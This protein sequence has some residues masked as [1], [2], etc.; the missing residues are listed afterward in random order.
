MNVL[1]QTFEAERRRL[2]GVAYR[3]LGSATEA[4][5]VL[6][7]AWLRASRYGAKV[8]DPRA[9]LRTIVVR[10]CVDAATSAR[11]R[12]E[13]YVGPWLPEP[14]L[15][16]DLDDGAE[17]DG[18]TA[19]RIGRAESVSMALL[20]VLESL[21]PLER[22]VFLLREVFDYEF[23]E[24]AA[25]LERSEAA[26]RQLFHRAR[27]HVAERRA[28]FEPF[29][30]D[31]DRLLST[32]LGAVASGEVKEVEALLAEGCVVTSDGG[33]RAR[34][35]LKAVFGAERAARLLT[36]LAKKAA[37]PYAVELTRLNGA[38]AVVLRGA[39][40]VHSVLL[41]ALEHGQIARLYF[42]LN[43]DKLARLERSLAG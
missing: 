18:P 25:C 29:P 16:A 34:A 3:M 21:S 41:F 28:R 20:V 38:P 37:S 4:D 17:L 7:D 6:Q 40:R 9:L 22:A 23:D 19:A 11:A 36:G 14:I 31:A 15:D 39:G 12:R 32:F 43:P 2:F 27:G 24:I 42:V 33:G 8:G 13:R 10:L 1:I 30:S 35:A 5:D 26:C